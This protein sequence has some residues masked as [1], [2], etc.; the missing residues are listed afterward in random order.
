MVYYK[1]KDFGRLSMEKKFGRGPNAT[2]CPLL[3]KC[4]KC[5]ETLTVLDFYT[6]RGKNGRKDILDQGRNSR[7]KKCNIQAYVEL[8][9]EKKL[10]YGVRTR[11]NQ[12]DVFFDLKIED[13]VIPKTCPALGIPIE[14]IVGKGRI[15]FGKNWNSPT[16]DR[17]D[18]TRGY[19][20][21]NIRVISYRANFLKNEATADELEAIA[22]YIREHQIQAI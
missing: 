20:P 15:D 5:K 6:S 3:M 4:A 8:S 11:V 10:W 19:V 14:P 12:R 1:S 2:C 21:D 18:P 16:I 13:I 17:V 7:C 22:R 9:P